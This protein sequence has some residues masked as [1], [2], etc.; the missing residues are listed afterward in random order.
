MAAFGGL[1]VFAAMAVFLLS[2]VAL[3]RPLPRLWL[4]TRKRAALGLV[5]SVIL[6]GVGG[7]ML[8]PAPPSAPKVAKPSDAAKP[9][10]TA[11]GQPIQV[12]DAALTVEKV[13]TRS[14]VG[15][16]YAYENASEGGVLVVIH[17]KIK[18]TGSKPLKA[19]SIPR[20]KLTDPAGT[21]YDWDVAKTSAYQMQDGDIDRKVWSDL[22]PGI[23]VR[24]A[25]VFEVSA[26][27]FNPE[28][29]R[30][31]VNGKTGVKLK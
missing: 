6:F 28:T 30:A 22:N 9:D 27:Q 17:T 1:L 26:E 12:G 14:R 21:E 8:P 5:G 4:P 13:D 11:L 18:N 19:F 29:W 25:V 31:V 23:T 16:E 24:D 10:F 2:L 3:I 15:I 7:S 20:I